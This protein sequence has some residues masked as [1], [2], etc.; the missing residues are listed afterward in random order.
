MK[1]SRLQKRYLHIEY[2]CPPSTD[3]VQLE[4]INAESAARVKRERR[5]ANEI[6]MRTVQRMQLQMTAPL[7]IG[8]EQQ[9]MSLR[10]QDD[11]FDLEGAENALKRGGGLGGD[12]ADDIDISDQEEVNGEGHEGSDMEE[13]K[14]NRLE[15][16]LDGSYEAYQ[17]RLRDRDAKFKAKEARRTNET[18]EVW[19][20][21][22]DEG[23][24]DNEDQS[25]EGGWDEMQQAKDMSE[26]S[27]DRDSSEDEDEDSREVIV[28]RKRTRTPT[29]DSQHKLKRTRLITKLDDPKTNAS[30]SQAA[31]IWFSQ[32]V[33]AGMEVLDEDDMA[34]DEQESDARHVDMVG[35]LT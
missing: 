26:A 3:S 9:D 23:G 16:E 19:S 33:F 14:V 22:P 25:D 12:D 35:Y 7:D 1:N 29:L 30:V 24:A 15:A 8:L 32:D 4:R 18:P 10:G 2:R 17:N 5:R 20:G 34:I 6:K 31:H 27:S 21:I 11:I 13:E 28:G